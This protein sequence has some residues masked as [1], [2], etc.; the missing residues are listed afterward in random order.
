MAN[1]GKIISA[2]LLGAAAGAALGILFAPDKGSETRKKITGKI[3]DLQDDFEDKL[4]EGKTA[5]K[6]AR[7]QFANKADELKD[8]AKSR[9]EDLKQNVSEKADEYKSKTQHVS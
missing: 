2:L 1:N 6:N 5:M 9:V 8:K 4:R 7:D 3:Q